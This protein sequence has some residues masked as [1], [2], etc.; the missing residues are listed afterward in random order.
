MAGRAVSAAR[1]V[2]GATWHGDCGA[3]HA[4]GQCPLLSPLRHAAAVAQGVGGEGSEF[5]RAPVSL[6]ET[7]RTQARSAADLREPM[8]RGA[9]T[10]V[11]QVNALLGN[12]NAV[13]REIRERVVAAA[14]LVDKVRMIEKA[15]SPEDD[16]DPALLEAEIERLQR[17]LKKRS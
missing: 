11:D 5:S 16:H 10:L 15:Q 17:E 2:A 13:G 12:P 4:E 8:L 9:A 7:S 6:P 1:K 14:V 3:F